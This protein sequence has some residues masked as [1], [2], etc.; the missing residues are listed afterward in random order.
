MHIKGRQI[1]G[2]HSQLY[3]DMNDIVTERTFWTP[4]MFAWGDHWTLLAW[5]ELLDEYRN[6]WLDRIRCIDCLPEHY[7]QHPERNL[8]H[9]LTRVVGIED[10][11]RPV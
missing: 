11:Q 4:D 3:S 6:F 9:Y 5:C 2:G 7:S 8:E 1:L 10:E